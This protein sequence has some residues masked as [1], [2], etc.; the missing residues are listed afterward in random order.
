VDD[1]RFWDIIAHCCGPDASEEHWHS[2]LNSTLASL[3]PEDIVGFGQTFD[4]YTNAAYTAD[5]WGAA[6]L[7]NGGA[8]DDG[9]IYFR[10]WLVGRGKKVYETALANP[11]SLADVVAPQQLYGESIC[12]AALGAWRELGLSDDAYLAAYHPH[13]RPPHPELAGDAWDFGDVDEVLRRF[14]RLA[15]LYIDDYHEDDE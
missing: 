7:I 2:K 8:S 4:R 13:G 5:L 6:H 1:K 11:D 3:S 15:A 9:F 12:G 10:C 14:P